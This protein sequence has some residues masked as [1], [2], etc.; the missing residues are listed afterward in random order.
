MG[1]KNPLSDYL[2]RNTI[3]EASGYAKGKPWTR[4]IWDVTAVAW[5]LNDN[6]QFME[7]RLVPSPIPQYDDHYGFDYRRPMITVVTRIARD[8]LMEEL[9]GRLTGTKFE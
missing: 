1:E 4:V 8:R 3:A 7:S 5:L 9:I 6:N 2:C